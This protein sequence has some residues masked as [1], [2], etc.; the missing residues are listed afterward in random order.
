MFLW[1][2]WLF[3]AK[4]V[5]NIRSQYFNPPL[6][7]SNRSVQKFCLEFYIIWFS[8]QF[9]GSALCSS[10]RYMY[11]AE[12]GC[13]RVHTEEICLCEISRSYG[14]EYEDN[15]FLGCSVL[16]SRC[17]R[18]TFQSFVMPPS[19]GRST[20]QSLGWVGLASQLLLCDSWSMYWVCKVCTK[21]CESFYLF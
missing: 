6:T 4:Q 12:N 9:Y 8:R 20:A 2:G 5:W 19:S 17:S 3:S 13:S 10:L 18:P 7:T 11:V 21:L 16:Y 14:G 1:W 15:N